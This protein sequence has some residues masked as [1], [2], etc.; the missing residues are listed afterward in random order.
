MSK[1]DKYFYFLKENILL[2]SLLLENPSKNGFQDFQESK[3][4]L[5]YQMKRFQLQDNLEKMLTPD[6]LHNINCEVKHIIDGARLLK[7]CIEERNLYNIE[8]TRK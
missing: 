5:R 1:I 7:T 6:D 8:D 4:K 2:I 3:L